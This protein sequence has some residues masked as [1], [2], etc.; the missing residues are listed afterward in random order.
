VRH[1]DGILIKKSDDVSGAPALVHAM[2]VV[3]TFAPMTKNEADQ[4]GVAVRDRNRYVKVASNTGDV[5]WF[6]LDKLDFNGDQIPIAAPWRP[7]QA[8]R[9]VTP[10]A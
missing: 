1:R 5:A 3:R 4:H 6:M 9:A 8:R 10:I 7:K 2:T